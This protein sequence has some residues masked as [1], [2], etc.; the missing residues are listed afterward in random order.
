MLKRRNLI[1]GAVIL[2]AII[3]AIVTSGF[4]NAPEAEAV[5][6]KKGII[7]EYIELRGK[8]ELEKRDKVFSKIQGIVKN[9][10][11]NEGDLVDAGTTILSLDDED[12]KISLDK[13]QTAYDAAKSQFAELSGSIKPEHLMQA[14]ARLKQALSGIKAA[15]ADYNF[16]KESLER[17]RSLYESGAA[18][19]QDMETAELMVKTAEA[20]VTSAKQTFSMVESDFGT[21][22]KGVSEHALKAAESN[23][24]QARLTVEELKRAID[25]TIMT[26]GMKGV[27]LSRHIEEGAI[28][29][30]GMLLCEIGDY[31]SAYIKTDVL[32]DDAVRIS[33]GQKALITGDAAQGHV[34]QGE[35]YYVAPEAKSSISSLGVEQQR[36]EVRIKYD[37]GSYG[38]KPGYALDVNIINS[39]KS[40]VIYLPYKSVF[41]MDGQDCV[42]VING[43]KLEIR[44]VETGIENDDY[45]EIT[46]G[47]S[48]GENVVTNPDNNLKPGKR[49]KPRLISL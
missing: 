49:V 6:A 16:K 36:V 14:E 26:S 41:E 29:L 40:G 25:R 34:I 19:K 7:R 13:A 11:I 35:V 2:L 23:I 10:K 48:E 9:V 33:I 21:L 22:K 38:L 20:A 5:T 17:I 1:I 31:G 4:I 24:E 43:G 39:E 3:T 12:L 8:V 47:I 44:K 37:N 45:I 18:S 46:K 30:P 32:A 15:E 42:F 27:V 28:A